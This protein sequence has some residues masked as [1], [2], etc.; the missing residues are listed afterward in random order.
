VMHQRQ[1]LCA[2]A[3]QGTSLMLLTLRFADEVLPAT[4]QESSAKISTAELALAKQLVQSMQ[5]VFTASKFKD[6]YR[7]DLKRRVEEKIRKKETHSLNVD[8]PAAEER[9]KAQVI[10]LMAA[11]K[12]SLDRSGHSREPK[13]ARKSSNARKRA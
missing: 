5:G 10:D 7:S 1:H 3:P 13:T 11:L 12:A 2:I 9:P 6:T 4:E 8:E